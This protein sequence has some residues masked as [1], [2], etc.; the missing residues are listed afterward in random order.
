[1]RSSVEAYYPEEGESLITDQV[2]N[3]NDYAIQA[4]GTNKISSAE[5]S[6]LPTADSP[7]GVSGDWYGG[8][9]VNNV[10]MLQINSQAPFNASGSPFPTPACAGAPNGAAGCFGWEQYLFS[11]TQGPAPG[12]G[13]SSLPGAP[14][15]TPAVFIE[16]LVVQLGNA[17]PG[18]TGMGGGGYVAKRWGW[19]L[20]F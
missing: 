13:Q 3:G 9:P 10:F 18:P 17:L 16:Y 6:F 19:I 1:M 8:G 14:G 5:G 7:T 4:S 15:T 11:Q 20:R 2:G 12:A